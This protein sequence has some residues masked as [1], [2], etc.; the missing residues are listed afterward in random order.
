MG[1]S[2]SKTATNAASSE[3]GAGKPGGDFQSRLNELVSDVREIS[4]KLN[5]LEAEHDKERKEAVAPQQETKPIEPGTNASP[6][7][8]GGGK[9][10]AVRPVRPVK[11]VKAVKAVK[12][13]KKAAPKKPASKKR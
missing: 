8:M 10:K 6:T 5:Q 4:R 11:P 12:A 9:R 3:S 13:V 2:G 1:S 7:Q